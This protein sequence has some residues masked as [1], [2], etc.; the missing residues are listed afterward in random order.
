MDT[1]FLNKYSSGEDL[2]DN[3]HKGNLKQ[4]RSPQAQTN[5]TGAS[6]DGKKDKSPKR[7]TDSTDKEDPKPV[8]KK[9][10]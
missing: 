8:K 2:R 5:A 9:L 4:S 10:L 1:I 7:K 6:G 3:Q